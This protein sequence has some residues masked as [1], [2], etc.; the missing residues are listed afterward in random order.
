MYLHLLG[1]KLSSVVVLVR[2][3]DTEQS[4]V[5]NEVNIQCTV[6]YV[7]NLKYMPFSFQCTE[8]EAQL[9]AAEKRLADILSNET[10]SLR[11]GEH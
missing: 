5:P 10:D 6:C 2:F 9:Q 8:A 11:K 4:N 3:H 7:I 1:N